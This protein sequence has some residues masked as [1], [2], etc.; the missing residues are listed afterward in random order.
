LSSKLISKLNSWY[1]PVIT[2]AL[3]N[4]KKSDVWSCRL[5]IMAVYLRLWEFIPTLDEGDF[6]IQPV[7]KRGQHW[8][9]R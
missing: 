6:V 3:S 8:L 1:L 5:L 9:K 4:T 2:W 7:L